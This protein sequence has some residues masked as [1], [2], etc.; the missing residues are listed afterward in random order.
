MFC[1]GNVYSTMN[2]RI[3]QEGEYLFT[4]SLKLVNFIGGIEKVNIESLLLITNVTTN[5]I[6]YNFGC[7]GFGG[8]ILNNIVTLEY[9]TTSMNLGDRLQIIIYENIFQSEE[10]LLN[11]KRNTATLN[12]IVELLSVQ[13]ELLKQMF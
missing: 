1:N 6:I 10:Y 12:Q 2:K 7:S 13:N 5:T 3:L 4:P 11:I 9:D 8:T